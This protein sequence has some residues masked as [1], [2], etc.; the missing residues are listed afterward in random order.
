MKAK[1]IG[2]FRAV[3][4]KR[5]M[6]ADEMRKKKKEEEDRGRKSEIQAKS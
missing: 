6:R 5:K 4:L 1:V 3:A 2:P